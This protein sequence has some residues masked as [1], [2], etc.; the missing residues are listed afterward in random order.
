MMITETMMSE[1]ADQLGLSQLE[2][3]LRN[4]YKT[5]DLT[6]YN[7]RLLDWHMPALIEQVLKDSNYEQ[8]EKDI[9][10]F[11]SSNQWK[12]RGI[13]LTPVKYGLSFLARFLNQGAALVNIYLD[14]S[15]AV[16]HGGVEMG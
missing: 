2:L 11:N 7:M 4:M 14:G 12:K 15:V 1:V 16:S 9:E 3:R 10:A 6:H 8:Q 13:A 5:D